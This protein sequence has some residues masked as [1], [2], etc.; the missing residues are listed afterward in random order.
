VRF[1]SHVSAITDLCA[2]SGE[3]EMMAEYGDMDIHRP[4]HNG[5]TTTA[6]SHTCRGHAAAAIVGRAGLMFL[7]ACGMQAWIAHDKAEYVRI[8]CDAARDVEK[9][10]DLRRGLR[11]RFLASPA[12][13]APRFAR[14]F[15]EIYRTAWVRFASGG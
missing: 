3:A 12:C 11:A 8:A 10:A 15:E 14:A 13:D 2:F 5:S 9:L 7:A 4:P 1:A 6:R